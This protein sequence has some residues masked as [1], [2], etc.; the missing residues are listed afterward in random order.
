MMFDKISK[1]LM[2]ALIF[3]A[4]AIN[5]SFVSAEELNE[6]TAVE[7][8]KPPSIFDIIGWGIG[9]TGYFMK[10]VSEQGGEW[11]GIDSS[12]M[13]LFLLILFLYVIRAKANG[14]V[15]WI[16]ILMIMFFVATG[17]IPLGDY[18]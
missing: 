8:D 12:I 16:F 5:I 11:F 4:L 13:V 18:L 3:S 10:N 1:I 17:L 7:D 14:W 15:F 6:T 2:L 9:T